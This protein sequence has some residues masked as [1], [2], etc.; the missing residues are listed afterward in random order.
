M[1]LGRRGHLD[2]LG[3]RQP[4]LDQPQPFDVTDNYYQTRRNFFEYAARYYRRADAN[5]AGVFELEYI[6][7]SYQISHWI[8]EANES[9]D[10][11]FGT[12]VPHLR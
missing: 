5:V 8:K 4:T 9:K 12:F 7:A 2:L 11:K 3:G 6:A 10:W 1:L